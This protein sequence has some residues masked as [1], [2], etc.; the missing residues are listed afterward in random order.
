MNAKHL[1]VFLLIW[2]EWGKPEVIAGQKSASEVP[3]F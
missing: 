3:A 2:P 1:R